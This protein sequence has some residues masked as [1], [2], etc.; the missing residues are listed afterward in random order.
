MQSELRGDTRT[1]L[2]VDDYEAVLSIVREFLESQGFCVLVATDASQ[3]MQIAQAYMGNIDALL[4][5]ARLPKAN[6]IAIS[7]QLKRLRPAM[8]VIVMSATL[9]ETIQINRVANLHAHFLWKPF[10]NGELLH[11]INEGI[12]K[13][14]NGALDS[15]EGSG[16]GHNRAISAG[17]I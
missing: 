11:A 10:T 12:A 13:H 7:E 8:A 4:I 15:A 9:D 14:K 16:S 5:E 1:I 3:A 2:V 17:E 6:G